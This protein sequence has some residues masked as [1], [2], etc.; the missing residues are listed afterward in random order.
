MTITGRSACS[1]LTNSSSASPDSPGMRRSLTSTA[2]SASLAN[3]SRN[4]AG[5]VNSRGCMP[6]RSSARASTRRTEAS[7]S[8]IQTSGSP[9]FMSNRPWSSDYPGLFGYRKQQAKYSASRLAFELDAPTV[10][11]DDFLG[12]G[13]PKPAAFVASGDQRKEQGLGQLDRHAATVV[14]DL[15]GNGKPV[16]VAVPRH[17]PGRPCPQHDSIST[18]LQRVAPQV[19]QR[20]EQLVGVQFEFRQT[21]IVIAFHRHACVG[22]AAQQP[23]QSIDR[24]VDIAMRHAGRTG[25]RQQFIDQRMQTIGLDADDVGKLAPAGIGLVATKKLGCTPQAGQRVA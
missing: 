12:D 16:E 17:A 1:A 22:F 11:I 14:G 6:S 4:P 21:G 15:H 10:T 24:L 20:L 7:S 23:L 2:G 13:K 18:R 9:V 25:R 19:E 5:A 3:A 8:T